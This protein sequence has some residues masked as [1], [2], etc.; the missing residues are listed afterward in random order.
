MAN[1]NEIVNAIKSEHIITRHIYKHHWISGSSTI[2][3]PITIL[4]DRVNIQL[5]TDHNVF[6]DAISR[7]LSK[8]HDLFTEGYFCKGDGSCP[9]VLRF[10]LSKK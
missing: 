9:S 2:V 6:E 5:D 3:Y 4:E 7:V 1:Q 8:H 10:I